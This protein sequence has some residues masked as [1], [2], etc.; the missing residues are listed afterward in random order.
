MEGEKEEKGK[1]EGD[2]RRTAVRFGGGKRMCA[3]SIEGW[4]LRAVLESPRGSGKAQRARFIQ[5]YLL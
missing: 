2:A 1:E 5:D 4:L 3:S